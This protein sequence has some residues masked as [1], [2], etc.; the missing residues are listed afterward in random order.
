MDLKKINDNISV[1]PQITPEDIPAIKAAGFV[2]IVNNR[3]D[4][5]APDQ[6]AGA[7]I[8]AAAEAAGLGYVFI[9]MGR[10][11]VSPEM[12]EQTRAALE[13][14]AGPVLCF[15]RSGTR[16]ATLW[17]LSQAG[18]MSADEIISAAASAGYDMSHLAGHLGR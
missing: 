2:T 6:P 8:K 5:E 18:K 17:S 4:G 1:S 12:I 7:E 3:P 14:S 9:P 11:G 15:C 10:E 16:S 13:G